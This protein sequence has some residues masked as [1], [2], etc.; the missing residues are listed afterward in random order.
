MLKK[1][2]LKLLSLFIYTIAIMSA[3][4]PSQ[5]SIYQ[6]PCPAKLK[7]KIEDKNLK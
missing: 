7:V 3:Y 5:A 4:S 2:I 1:S 6:I